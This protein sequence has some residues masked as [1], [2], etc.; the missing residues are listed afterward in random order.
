MTPGASTWLSWAMSKSPARSFIS[1][2]MREPK[3]FGS[4]NPAVH[5]VRN[6]STS[7][8]SRNSRSCGTRK[9]SGSR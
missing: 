3:V 2:A 1:R 9:G 4:G 7:I 6:S 5:M 8:R